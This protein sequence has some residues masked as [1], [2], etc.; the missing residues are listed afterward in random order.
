M[1][2]CLFLW[3]YS[4]FLT[5]I[6]LGFAILMAGLIGSLLPTF[7][8][9]LHKLYR[10]EAGRQA[11]LVESINGAA[12]IKSHRGIALGKFLVA[13]GLLRGIWRHR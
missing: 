2:S 4:S 10:A 1:F 11:M 3:F 13:S 5:L 8:K 7:R 12:T 9:R 6:V